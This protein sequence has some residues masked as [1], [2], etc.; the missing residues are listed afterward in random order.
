MSLSF[1]RSFHASA[2]VSR[3]AKI[4]IKPP[5]HHLYRYKKNVLK[6]AFTKT[7][8]THPGSIESNKYVPKNTR[9]DRVVDHY[10]NTVASDMLLMGYVHG[11]S[12]RKGNKS[13]PW[14]FTSPYH[15]GR[16]AQPPR[17]PNKTP[18]KDVH[19]RTWKNIPAI[20]KITINCTDPGT[21]LDHEKV[22]NQKLLLQQ[23]TGC[24]A[25]EVRSRSNIMTWKLRKGYPM[26]A[27]VEITGEK[28]ADFMTSLTELV[29]PRA[30]NFNGIQNSS[31][32]RN[33]NIAFG[34]IPEDVKNF[35]EVEANQ[36]AYLQMYGM[37][38]TIHTSAQ[39][40]SEARALLSA[41]N[42]PFVGK[43]KHQGRS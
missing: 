13:R 37:H 31:G 41:F 4:S 42:F 34:L 2:C 3:G 16:P 23:I 32:D 19:P 1:S 21:V 38:V 10:N 7:L 30:I 14:D 15:L 27:K 6:P 11:Q 17:G 12:V 28:I 5:V 35:P 25:K 20:T 43:E 24:P 36:D 39:A 18:T 33:G 26:G 22:I 40:D 9:V 8:L 29:L